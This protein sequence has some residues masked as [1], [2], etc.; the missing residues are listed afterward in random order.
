VAIYQYRI[1][2]NKLRR[3]CRIV[4]EFHQSRGSYLAH[5]LH[6]LPYRAEFKQFRNLNAI[7]SY[8]RE[9]LGYSNAQFLW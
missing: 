2:T 8:H 6:R 5:L 3:L 9:L 7:K 4:D 1:E